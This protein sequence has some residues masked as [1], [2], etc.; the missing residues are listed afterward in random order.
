MC[1]LPHR[2][3]T[4]LLVSSCEPSL[5]SAPPLPRGA[6]PRSLTTAAT[7]TARWQS[8]SSVQ[9]GAVPLPLWGQS[10]SLSLLPICS[11]TGSFYHTESLE[12]P[13]GPQSSPGT[14]SLHGDQPSVLPG[15]CAQVRPSAALF[16]ARRSPSF[17]ESFFGPTCFHAALPF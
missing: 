3:T 4:E 12:M 5:Y 15:S 13:G 6:R 10:L 9:G 1:H 17:R 16:Q 7:G 14:C 11:L 8:C 2:G